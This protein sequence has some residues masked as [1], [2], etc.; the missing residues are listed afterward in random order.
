PYYPE[1]YSRFTI[2]NMMDH[3]NDFLVGDEYWDLLG[4]KNTLK[5][6]LDTFDYVGKKLEKDITA[7]IKQV[8]E[9]KMDS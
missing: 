8:A 1:S 3:P 9:E 7:K 2:Q 5:E 4:G 6:L